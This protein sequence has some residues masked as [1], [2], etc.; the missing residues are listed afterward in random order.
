MIKRQLIIGISIILLL[1]SQFPVS[2]SNREHYKTL[3]N[4][5]NTLYVGGTGPNNYSTIQEAVDTA[6]EGDTIYVYD[7]SSPYNESVTITK[8][9]SIQRDLQ[10]VESRDSSKHFR[11]SSGYSRP[12]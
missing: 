10:F 2:G 5:G 3:I 1:A 11:P 9:L 8:S 6:F 4:G 12:K 7:D